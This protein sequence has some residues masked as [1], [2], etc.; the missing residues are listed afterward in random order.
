MRRASGER[1]LERHPR[2]LHARAA[3]RL[4]LQMRAARAER[5]HRAHRR[6]PAPHDR[7]QD[8][9]FLH[10]AP[11][12]CCCRGDRGRRAHREGACGTCDGRRSPVKPRLRE[13]PLKTLA[14]S[15]GLGR[16]GPAPAP[17]RPWHAATCEGGCEGGWCGV[18]A[19]LLVRV[20]ES[21]GFRCRLARPVCSCV[22][23]GGNATSCAVWLCVRWRRLAWVV[24]DGTTE[25]SLCSVRAPRYLGVS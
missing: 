11:L 17:Q 8:R 20:H 4:G 18:S 19:A 5:A 24:R 9:L 21:R 10:A 12:G 16:S 7:A 6:A 14:R 2:P 3:T 23:L 15:R 22:V 1:R 13:P 25:S